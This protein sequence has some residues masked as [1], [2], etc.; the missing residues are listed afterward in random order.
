MVRDDIVTIL[1]GMGFESFTDFVIQDGELVWISKTKT[2]PTDKE[3]DLEADVIFTN[4]KIKA[5]KATV[6]ESLT[7]HIVDVIFEN[8]ILPSAVILDQA[9]ARTKQTKTTEESK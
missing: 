1:T 9:I 3:I 8:P 7:N 2:Q 4:I 6:K 5:I